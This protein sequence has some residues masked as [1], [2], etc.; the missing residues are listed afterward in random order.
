M[1]PSREKIIE[2]AK[3]LAADVA[4]YVSEGRDS[5]PARIAG[6]KSAAQEQFEVA[7]DM[8]RERA[9]QI[10]EA[11]RENVWVTAG[12]AAAVGALIGVLFSRNKRD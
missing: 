12:I 5:A 6:L 9:R 7:K 3:R 4:A 1:A 8:T 2:D 11:A 10:D